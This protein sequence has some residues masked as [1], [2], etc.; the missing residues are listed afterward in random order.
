VPFSRRNLFYRDNFRCQYCGVRTSTDNL[1]IDHVIPRSRGGLS[2]WTN[3]VLACH[4]CNVRK[5]NRT[6]HEASMRLSRSPAQPR[7]PVY[8]SLGADHRRDSWQRFISEPLPS[9]E[10]RNH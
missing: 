9:P 2:T 1:S 8:L 4:D 5:G 10:P 7:W 3:C 6:P